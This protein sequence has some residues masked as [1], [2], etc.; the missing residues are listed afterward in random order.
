MK[1][2]LH[3]RI[4]RSKRLREQPGVGHNRWHPDIPA[5]ARANVG[6]VVAIETVDCN[7]GNITASWTSEQLGNSPHGV[8]HPLTGPL[9]INGAE[10]GD[11]LEVH[12]LDI[13]PQAYGHT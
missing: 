5:I 7:D 9:H 3:L 13:V 2:S 8:V 11:I 1:A 12:I 6:D 4:D 10:A